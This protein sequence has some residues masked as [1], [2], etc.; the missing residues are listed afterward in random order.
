MII[1]RFILDNFQID[2]YFLVKSGVEMPC[3]VERLKI[4][5]LDAPQFFSEF[6]AKSGGLT[7]KVSNHGRGVPC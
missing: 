1:L 3:G 7:D 2:I 4:G 5:S 6:A